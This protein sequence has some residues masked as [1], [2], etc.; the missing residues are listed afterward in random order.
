MSQLWLMMGGLSNLTYYHANYPPTHHP[1]YRA[2]EAKLLMTNCR[3]D[4]HKN[5]K[6]WLWLQRF[7]QA[8]DFGDS[9]IAQSH[10]QELDCVH[11]CKLYSRNGTC[12]TQTSSR[13]L[14]QHLQSWLRNRPL[15]WWKCSLPYHYG[16]DKSSPK[17]YLVQYTRLPKQESR[18]QSNLIEEHLI[19][20]RLSCSRPKIRCYIFYQ[21]L[22]T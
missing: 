18:K 15:S 19:L 5:S 2:S 8:I 20:Y 22:H 17:L 9:S 3:Y 13:H 16:C 12:G 21:E 11:S 4:F 14:F 6:P 1:D 10:H 7:R